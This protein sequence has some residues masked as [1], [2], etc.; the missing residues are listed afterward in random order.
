MAVVT[1]LPPKQESAARAI[2]KR[3]RG[4]QSRAQMRSKAGRLEQNQEV[5]GQKLLD[6]Q[7]AGEVADLQ[8]SAC[9]CLPLAA[10][11]S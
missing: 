10:Q 2:Q 1:Q 3:V 11:A 4:V 8:A 9:S 7:Q 5:V 6:L